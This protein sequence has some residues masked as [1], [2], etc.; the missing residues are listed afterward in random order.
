MILQPWHLYLTWQILPG[1][2]EVMTLFY[3]SIH[4]RNGTG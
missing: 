4:P 2:I 1:L 3:Q